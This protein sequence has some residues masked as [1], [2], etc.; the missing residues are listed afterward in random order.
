MHLRR[1]AISASLKRI[2]TAK[3]RSG[4]GIQDIQEFQE[5]DRIMDDFR[6]AASAHDWLFPLVVLQHR[7]TRRPKP[8]RK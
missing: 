7:V 1:R 3:K 8:E 6:T 2:G 5:Q 4:S